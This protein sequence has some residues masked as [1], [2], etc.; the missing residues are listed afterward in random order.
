MAKEIVKTL[1]L[2]E[3]LSYNAREASEGTIMRI[4]LFNSERNGY[5]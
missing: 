3:N 2:C 5:A 1:L 4:T